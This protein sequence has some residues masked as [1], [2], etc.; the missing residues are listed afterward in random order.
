MLH[1]VTI[2]HG[3]FIAA[4]YNQAARRCLFISH[5]NRAVKHGPPFTITGIKGVKNLAGKIIK[6]QA[7]RV[8]IKIQGQ[9][10]GG[11]VVNLVAKPFFVP[12]QLLLY[13]RVI[14]AGMFGEQGFGQTLFGLC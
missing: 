9:G 11:D 1:R 12:A 4:F 3:G 5:T 7:V 14:Q 2:V 8:G 13:E 6:L 10:P